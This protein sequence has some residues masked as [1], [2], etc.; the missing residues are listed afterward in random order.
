MALAAQYQA[1]RKG[2]APSE[3]DS[4]GF[5][6]IDDALAGN[7][8]SSPSRDRDSQPAGGAEAGTPMV[9]T[10]ASLERLLGEE[11]GDSKVR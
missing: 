1:A 3:L 2:G 5:S 6:A 4:S 11:A 9:D 7:G 10:I 8:S